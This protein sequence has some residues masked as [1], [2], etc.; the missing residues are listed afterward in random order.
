MKYF[1]NRHR[2]LLA[3]CL[4]AST[5]LGA[6]TLVL[7]NGVVYKNVK[8][9][10]QGTR[11]YVYRQGKRRLSFPAA[12]IRN[13]IPKKVHWPKAATTRKL[14]DGEKSPK[15]TKGTS[16]ASKGASSSKGTKPAVRKDAQAQSSD[17]NRQ[18]PWVLAAW[19][20]VPIWSGLYQFEDMH[21]YGYAF[22]AVELLATLNLVRWLQPSKP[23]QEELLPVLLV[24]GAVVPSPPP[25][26][27]QPAPR[28]NAPLVRDLYLVITQ[29]RQVVAS[30][31]K[32]YS[33]ADFRNRRLRA[34]VFFLSVLAGDAIV[35]Y[36]AGTR[37]KE[38]PKQAYFSWDLELGATDVHAMPASE[39]FWQPRIEFRF[40]W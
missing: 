34:G 26:L 20:A 12:R 7:K 36:L 5:G 3:L 14:S 11:I 13:L 17:G 4:L 24:A 27:G 2:V 10:I 40:R 18:S 21:I 28:F 8:T 9:R 6:D 29:Q 22:S 23:L 30:D 15:T 35:S 19:G 16:R 33:E 32:T 37:R 38:Q 25:A 31:G 1:L 39:A